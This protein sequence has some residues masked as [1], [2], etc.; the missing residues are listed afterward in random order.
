MV[1]FGEA[2]DA[3]TIQEAQD[4]CQTMGMDLFSPVNSGQV[5][6][7]QLLGL[8]G[9]GFQFYIKL[10]INLELFVNI[11]GVKISFVLWIAV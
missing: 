1:V 3:T 4:H 10:Y 2:D 11:S 8:Q 9:E 5:N 7:L 6:K